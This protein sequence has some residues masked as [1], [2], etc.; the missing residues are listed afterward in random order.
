MLLTLIGCLLI[1]IITFFAMK[2]AYYHATPFEIKKLKDTVDYY[3]MHNEYLEEKISKMENDCDYCE[4]CVEKNKLIA[5]YQKEIERMNKK[6][7]CND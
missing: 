2:L 6:W 7:G 3:V 1:I 5:S 4:L